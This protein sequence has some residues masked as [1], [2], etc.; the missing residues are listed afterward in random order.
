ML[1]SRL[2][3]ALT[4]S[5]NHL[6]KTINFSNPKYVGDPFNAV[7]IFNEKKIDELILIDQD[8]SLNNTEPNYKLIESIASVSSMPLC[9]AGG[10]KT[11]DQARKIIGLGFEKV[12][13]N[14]QLF[15][16]VKIISDIS[17]S[18]GSQS[19]VACI[20]VIKHKG[21]YKPTSLSNSRIHDSTL[22][23]LINLYHS[24][25]AG[26]ILINNVDLDGRMTGYDED[27]INLT[28]SISRLPITYLGG[29]G[30]IEDFNKIYNKHYPIGLAASSF[31]IFR[32]PFRAVLIS[33]PD[34]NQ[35]KN[36][37]HE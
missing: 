10:I 27:L 20:D 13:I 33:Y 5:N 2:I 25:G 12:A 34:K 3:A 15:K 8:A 31:F 30:S 24:E 19:I 16:N 29:A 26:E 28:Q 23:D 21:L 11:S 14:N 7:R 18:I 9:Y 36:I 17:S 35:L 32:G 37:I 1:R 4:M 22:E 6:V